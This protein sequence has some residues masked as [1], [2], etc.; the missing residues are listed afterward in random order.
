LPRV[1]LPKGC[2]GFADGDRKYM[3]VNGPGSYVNL[4]DGSPQLRKL[5]NQDYAQAG[6]VDAG[7]EKFYTIRQ[8]DGRWCVECRF[9]GH[10]WATQCPRCGGDTVPE[11][12]MPPRRLPEGPYTP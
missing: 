1:F 10:R 5:A 6:L 2:A 7:P 12:E 11:A 4:E 9:L 3:A 8:N